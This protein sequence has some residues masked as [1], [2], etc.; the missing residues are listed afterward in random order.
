MSLLLLAIPYFGL[1]LG[2]A[3]SP[4][5]EMRSTF[6]LAFLTAGHLILLAAWGWLVRS[7][8]RDPRAVRAWALAF[9]AAAYALPAALGLI[10]A[11]V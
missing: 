10:A 1:G 3:F 11:V 5:A 7:Y 6:D 2:V 8:L 9:T 4:V